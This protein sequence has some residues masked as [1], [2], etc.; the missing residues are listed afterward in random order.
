MSNAPDD[1][2]RILVSRAMM[3]PAAVSHDMHLATDDLAQPVA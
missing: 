2:G 1:G 3:T